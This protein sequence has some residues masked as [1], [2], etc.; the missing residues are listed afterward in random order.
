MGSQAG[1]QASST[2]VLVGVHS[3]FH[4]KIV[5]HGRSVV[6]L[7]TPHQYCY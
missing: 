1:R 3:P 6:W 5:S 2:T 7:L 4:Y